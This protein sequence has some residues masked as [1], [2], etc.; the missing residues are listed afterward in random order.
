MSLTQGYKLYGQIVSLYSPKS[1]SYSSEEEKILYN[2][3]NIFKLFGKAHQLYKDGD[4]VAFGEKMGAILDLIGKGEEDEEIVEKKEVVYRHKSE[5]KKPKY[6]SDYASRSKRSSN[7]KRK[8]RRGVPK[9]KKSRSSR[10]SSSSRNTSGAKFR[11]NM[12]I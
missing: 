4:Y 12:L 9:L 5:Y 2:G 11:M 10:R 3:V 1:T 8:N 7:K 6:E